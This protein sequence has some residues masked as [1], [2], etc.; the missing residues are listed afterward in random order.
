LETISEVCASAAPEVHQFEPLAGE[1][2]EAAMPAGTA[3][4]GDQNRLGRAD[5]ADW[6]ISSAAKRGG[7][8]R[9]GFL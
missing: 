9:Y 8:R 2:A 6:R 7:A 4:A 5:E 3:R 1:D